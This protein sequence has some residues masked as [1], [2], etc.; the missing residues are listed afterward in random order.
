MI[1]PVIYFSTLFLL[2]PQSMNHRAERGVGLCQPDEE[3]FPL[4]LPKLSHIWETEM[5]HIM[6]SLL[7]AAIFNFPSTKFHLPSYI[8]S[9]H[10]STASSVPRPWPS[11]PRKIPQSEVSLLVPPASPATV[12]HYDP[13]M[14]GVLFEG[15]CSKYKE[16]F[17]ISSDGAWTLRQGQLQQEA[18]LAWRPSMWINYN[19]ENLP[20]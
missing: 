1:F 2:W 5:L 14:A 17:W 9:T 8:L 10:L 12:L 3:Y 19:I 13:A 11:P 15:Y 16:S 4:L 20:K 7:A 18:D 6:L